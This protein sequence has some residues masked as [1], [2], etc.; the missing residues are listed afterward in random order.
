MQ[1]ITRKTKGEIIDL[2][3]HDIQFSFN[4]HGHFVI[5][6]FKKDKPDDTVIVLT[7]GASRNLI[8]FAKKIDDKW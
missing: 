3:D 4:S 8:K 1:I 7:A 2:V 6:A 5:R